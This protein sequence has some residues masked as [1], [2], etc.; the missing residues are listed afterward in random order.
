MEVLTLLCDGL[1][2]R[3]F[4]RSVLSARGITLIILLLSLSTSF[5][6]SIH[7]ALGASGLPDLI[8]GAIVVPSTSICVG[9]SL[10]FSS[11]VWNNGTAPTPDGFGVL[12]YV[13]NASH[14]TIKNNTI[15]YGSLTN[16]SSVNSQFTWIP[17]TNGTYIVGINVDPTNQVP[18]SN[19]T[20]NP[21]ETKPLNVKLLPCTVK[22][23]MTASCQVCII[24][25]GENATYPLSLTIT[26]GTTEKIILQLGAVSKDGTPLPLTVFGADFRPNN[27]T[28]SFPTRLNITTTINTAPGNYK[29][30]VDA[31]TAL[32]S[33]GANSTTLSL[34]V[35]QR[36]RF[37]PEPLVYIP[38]QNVSTT[39]FI[40]FHGRLNITVL[41]AS[42]DA[43]QYFA[44][45]LNA[46]STIKTCDLS[47]TCSL[48]FRFD[49]NVPE[50][51]INLIVN[52]S[53]N[54]P[55]IPY[56]I[57][58]TLGSR[59][60]NFIW[61]PPAI[62]MISCS[63][64]DFCAVPST[65]A[66]PLPQ[67]A[68]YEF[69]TIYV[70]SIPPVNQTLNVTLSVTQLYEQLPKVNASFKTSDT[71]RSSCFNRWV[72]GG[73]WLLAKP[74]TVVKVSLQFDGTTTGSNGTGTYRVNLK[75]SVPGIP[76]PHLEPIW[77]VV[78]KLTPA[79]LSALLLTSGL[80]TA[81]LV[82]LV[83]KR[84]FR[85]RRLRTL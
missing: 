76:L 54:A 68:N 27:V 79:S 81:M 18:E 19:K 44:F 82:A 57:N 37:Q 46:N 32:S 14:V 20:N 41:A 80:A 25:P 42:P 26:L 49:H 50:W 58:V 7:I 70:E 13:N 61:R 34:Q 74:G 45:K 53:K 52:V 65:R 1:P 77:I 3:V 84:I 2:A 75:A 40:G 5:S 67:I 36:L 31:R 48:D 83:V 51:G 43:A 15:F 56:E 47:K 78:F 73:C 23:N 4:L 9:N 17:T 60:Y 8:P 38:G 28:L 85:P 21:V 64:L 35:N 33:R 24:G 72:A 16:G 12:W 29:L 10:P 30:R 71:N 11:R 69:V 63:Y 62:D 39:A 66:Y 22:F 6:P 55:P 59:D